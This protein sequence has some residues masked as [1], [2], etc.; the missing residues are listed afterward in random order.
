MPDQ[1]AGPSL[2]EQ[3]E[4][5]GFLHLKGFC[6]KD[7]VRERNHEAEQLG[8]RDA[9]CA[10]L[11]ASMGKLIDAWNPEETLAP[12]FTTDEEEQTKAQGDS[13]YFLDSA[14][15]IHFSGKGAV[16]SEGKLRKDVPKGASLNKVG[17]G[18]HVVDE[19]FREYTQSAKVA[20]LVAELGWK[21]PVLPQSMY[22]FKQPTIGGEVTSHQA[23]ESDNIIYYKEVRSKLNLLQQRYNIAWAM[24]GPI[25]EI[26]QQIAILRRMLISEKSL[27]QQ[28][29]WTET[30]IAIMMLRVGTAN[31][32]VEA[33]QEILDKKIAIRDNLQDQLGALRRTKNDIRVMIQEPQQAEEDAATQMGLDMRDR[34][35]AADDANYE[36]SVSIGGPVDPSTAP[37]ANGSGRIIPVDSIDTDRTDA[38]AESLPFRGKFDTEE[39]EEG[40]IRAGS[41]LQVREQLRSGLLSWPTGRAAAAPNNIAQPEHTEDQGSYIS[42]EAKASRR[43]QTAPSSRSEVN[44]VK[45]HCQRLPAS[46]RSSAQNSKATTIKV[47]SD[48]GMSCTAEIHT[49]EYEVQAKI[50]PAL[51]CSTSTLRSRSSC[52][53]RATILSAT[54]SASKDLKATYSRAFR[55]ADA[56]PPLLTELMTEVDQTG[57]HARA[58]LGLDICPVAQRARGHVSIFVDGS[59]DEK[60][61]SPAA[62]AMAAIAKQPSL[63]ESYTIES[64]SASAI[65]IAKGAAQSEAH[66]KLG[67]LLRVLTRE[68]QA[69]RGFSF[70][71][72][73]SHEAHP[74]NELVDGLAK[75]EH[76]AS[77]LRDPDWASRLAPCGRTHE[78]TDPEDF[79]PAD[80]LGGGFEPPPALIGDAPLTVASFNATSKVGLH[81]N[82]MVTHAPYQDGQSRLIEAGDAHRAA[83]F[84]TMLCAILLMAWTADAS[85]QYSHLQEQILQAASAAFPV[86]KHF[87]RKPFTDPL[88]MCMI[89]LKAR[90]MICGK[91]SK[92]ST[93]MATQVVRTFIEVTRQKSLSSV[94]ASIGLK[95]AFYKV[96][97][98]L[99]MPNLNDPVDLA[100]AIGA[101]EDLGNERLLKMLAGTHASTWFKT[102]GSQGVDLREMISTTV[103]I[104]S[105]INAR[106]GMTVNFKKGRPDQPHVADE[107][108]LLDT[109]RIPVPDVLRLMRR[110]ARNSVYQA[111]CKDFLNRL[112]LLRHLGSAGASCLEIWCRAEEPMPDDLC[113]ALRTGDR[114]HAAALMVRGLRATEAE[115]GDAAAPKMVFEELS[116]SEQSQAWK[117]E[118][119]M[120]SGWEP[121]SEGLR[122]RGFAPLECEVGDLV[123]IHGQ[124]DHLSLPNVSK[125]KRDTFQLHLVEGPGEGIE[126][127]RRNW[128]QYPGSKPFP[129]LGAAAG[130]KRKAAEIS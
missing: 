120:P 83:I 53:S 48:G 34:P 87:P 19:A 18:L 126:W 111:C 97:R 29:A 99:V 8:E 9:E 44:D 42:E 91:F 112:R 114:N 129:R 89:R 17:H 13:D 79:L 80:A 63:A 85:V 90:L 37:R 51:S 130:A 36:G 96:I 117:W 104:A 11:Q 109:D 72:V 46:Q 66:P 86:Q 58:K 102:N 47:P 98:A 45:R 15:R 110:L 20:R 73:P 92:L 107:Q 60:K 128:L 64:D 62:W 21:D 71:R 106:Y 1:E 75:R 3:F 24:K 103:A 67:T 2:R 127:S 70:K 5:D 121:P 82:F 94:I 55:V 12:I 16:D 100:G 39:S 32:T 40:A 6:S 26:T 88:A 76:V 108:I 69:K 35:A 7:T 27:A 49:D 74:W 10:R 122:Q 113:D 23:D 59:F 68:A 28:S 101:A 84:K 31:K 38:A 81:V 56:Q 93:D 14:D 77:E 118:G 4:R 41:G 105:E 52:G 50:R 123:V 116:G 57:L 33:Q 54:S 95:S 125:L 22:I 61:L 78:T 124:V 65:Q 43:P 119:K 30:T 25:Q 115:A